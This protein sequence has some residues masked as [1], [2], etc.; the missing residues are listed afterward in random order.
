MFHLTYTLAI[1]LI[2]GAI[3]RLIFKQHVLDGRMKFGLIG[4]TVC[5][6]WDLQKHAE[7]FAPKLSLW[8]G[9][10]ALLTTV[11]LFYPGIRWLFPPADSGVEQ[12]QQR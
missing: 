1:I 2:T 5:V 10:L 11:A 8:L 7:K 3:L 6:L 12:N 4:L 9:V